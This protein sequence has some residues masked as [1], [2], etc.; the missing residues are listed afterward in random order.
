GCDHLVAGS[1][2]L[3]HRDRRSGR[4]AGDAQAARRRVPTRD[5]RRD[6]LDAPTSRHARRGTVMHALTV[7]RTFF[8]LGLLNIMQYRSDF[9][10]SLLNVVITLGTQ[11]LGLTVIFGQT[12]DLRGWT[13]DD[14]IVL[15]GIHMLVGGLLGLVIRPSMQALME[16]IRLG[17]FDF[18][19]TKPVDSQLFTSVQKVAPQSTTDM[20]FG[21]GV[22][23]VGITRLN[24]DLSAGSVL[25]FPVM[26]LAGTVIIY[27][28]MLFL[29]TLAF[30]FVRLDNVLVI[31]QTMFGNAGSWPI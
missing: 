11:L 4:E 10:I 8:R 20:L 28:F 12:E 7:A 5:P 24:E 18:V 31:F 13:R 23:I 3:G 29:S 17:T 27:S 19:L 16:G 2:H 22:I 25:L 15:I 14:L 26:L 30:W 6:R 9:F 1:D 21:L